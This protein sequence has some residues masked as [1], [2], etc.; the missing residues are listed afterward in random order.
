MVALIFVREVSDPLASLVKKI[1]QT[2]NEASGKYPGGRKLGTF[3][4]IGDGNGRADQLRDLA[5]KEG[6]QRVSLC[7]G[8]APP[9]YEVN[10]EA[11]V[12]VVI[13]NPNRPGRQ[14]VTA[15]FALRK[16]E[17]DETMS[18]AIVEALSKVLPK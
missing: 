9:R 5:R 2:I 14:S 17:L 12:T 11:D 4:I 16:G 10:N 1:D 15:N 13:Y 6:L 8:A 3:L 18:E 7:L